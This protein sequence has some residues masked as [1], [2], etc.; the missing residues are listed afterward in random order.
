MDTQFVWQDEFNIGVE[1]IDK[2]HQRL[3]KIILFSKRQALRRA[4]GF[5]IL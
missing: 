3:F 2:E 4:E 1:I 5:P